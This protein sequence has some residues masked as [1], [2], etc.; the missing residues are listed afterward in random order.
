MITLIVFKQGKQWLVEKLVNN[1]PDEHSIKYFGSHI[2]PV[3]FNSNEKVSWI[4]RKLA[5][6]NPSACVL[7]K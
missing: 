7:V 2:K 3:P 5:E 6:L 4:V 1:K